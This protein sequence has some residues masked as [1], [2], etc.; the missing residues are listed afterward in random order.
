MKLGYRHLHARRRMMK[1]LE[2]FPSRIG[3]R[4]ALDYLTFIVAILSPLALVPQVYAIYST[5]DVAGLTLSTWLS[6][7]FI[8]A[9]WVLYGLSHRTVPVIASNAL[10]S[11]LNFSIVIGIL[12][13]R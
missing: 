5:R 7:G 6:L 2:P 12:I 1:N 3:Y 13:Y 9:L 4:R 10:F 8:D 11:L